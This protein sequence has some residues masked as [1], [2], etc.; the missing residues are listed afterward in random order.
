MKS[1]IYMILVLFSLP[2]MAQD[3][4]EI[5]I[6]DTVYFGECSGSNFSYVDL[7]VKT[8]FEQDSISYDTINEWAFY[9][10]FFNTGDFNV[11]RLPCEYEGK[12]AVIKHMMSIED[13]NGQWHSVIIAMIVDGSSAAW[14]TEDAFAEGEVMLT[15]DP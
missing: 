3:E 10:R 6:G 7:Y 12:S 13:E 5:H 11:S 8:R 1:V 14:I 4:A 9:N 2:V 15:P